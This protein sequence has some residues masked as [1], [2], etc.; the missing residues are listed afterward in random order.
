MANLQRVR[1][2]K[3]VVTLQA[4][5]TCAAV[6]TKDLQLDVKFIGCFHCLSSVSFDEDYAQSKCLDCVDLASLSTIHRRDESFRKLVIFVCWFAPKYILLLLTYFRKTNSM[7]QKGQWAFRL[8]CIKPQGLNEGDLFISQNRTN[9]KCNY[10]AHFFLVHT[11]IKICNDLYE[12]LNQYY[13]TFSTVAKISLVEN[14][15]FLL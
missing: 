15:L 12:S 6:V 7:S 11:N 2:Q 10:L 9:W 13:T 14:Q 5:N 4:R 8:K 1:F 3:H